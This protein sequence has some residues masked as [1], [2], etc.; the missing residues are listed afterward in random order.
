M[1]PNGQLPA[2][3]WSF[4]DVNPP[5]HAWAALRVYQLDARRNGVADRAFLEGIFHK[6]LLNFTWWVNRKDADGNNIY[7]SELGHAIT[8]NPLSLV[9]PPTLTGAVVAV[10]PLG[11]NFG[12]LEVPLPPADRTNTTLGLV[13]TD[14]VPAGASYATG[15]TKVGDVIRWTV[16]S[17]VANGGVTQTTFAV[18]AA[19]TITNSDYR[20]V[21]DGGYNA[22]GSVPVVTVVSGG[23]PHTHR[24]FLPM[25]LR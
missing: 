9:S 1:H 24:S 21:A 4:G 25:V 16:A 5:V 22:I 6:L 3:E 13:I 14:I 2:Y 15:G 20:V 23:A 17:L 7:L 10:L 12:G 11:A 18:T 19:A 8:S